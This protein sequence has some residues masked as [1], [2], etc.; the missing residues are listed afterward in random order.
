MITYSLQAEKIRNEYLSEIRRYV[1]ASRGA[2]A[3][4]VLQDV[5][6]HIEGEL[7]DCDQPGSSEQLQTVLDKLG[8]PQQWIPAEDM[9]WWRQ[10]TMRL[11]SGPED[12]RLAYLSFGMLV[13]GSFIMWPL[14][15]LGSFCLSRAALSMGDVEEIQN[16]KWLIYPSLII[17]YGLCG[18]LFLFWPIVIPITGLAPGGRLIVTISLIVTIIWWFVLPVLFRK[19]S[20][21]LPLLLY[22]FGSRWESK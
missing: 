6:D 5:E 12:W 15:L 16:K 8:S 10:F 21:Y 4:E 3:E 11:R 22:P 14:A 1:G 17:V 20:K 19:F 18:I 9:S 13:I 2:D 7:Q